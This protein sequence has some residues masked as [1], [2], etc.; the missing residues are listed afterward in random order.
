[1]SKSK[2]MSKS[3][4]DNMVF[5]TVLENPKTGISR[6]PCQRKHVMILIKYDYLKD[7]VVSL[8]QKA[9]RQEPGNLRMT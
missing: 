2:Q 8:H 1:M 3:A 4:A 9:R 5:N 7:D 6:V